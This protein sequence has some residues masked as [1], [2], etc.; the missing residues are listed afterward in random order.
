M[1]LLALLLLLA[2]LALALQLTYPWGRVAF[3]LTLF[4][5]A[6]L[7]WNMAQASD[8]SLDVFTVTLALE[9]APRGFLTLALGLT[10]ALALATS[11][12]RDRVSL[13]FLFWSWI[14]WFLALAVS[15]FVIA[16]FAWSIGLTTTVLAMKPRQHQRASG[17]AYFL[18]LV[19]VATASLLLISDLVVALAVA[20]LAGA[21]VR[22][23]GLAQRRGE[24]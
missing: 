13:A 21:P 8:N 4:G 5:G 6:L 9:P 23:R 11:L 22:A 10:S 15:D 16:V 24:N 19:S 1:N 17:A 12:Q 2:V 20:H 7:A 14:P 18:V 3:V